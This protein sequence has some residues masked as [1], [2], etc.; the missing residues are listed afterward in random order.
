[1][2][3]ASSPLTRLSSGVSLTPLAIK[4]HAEPHFSLTVID[5]VLTTATTDDEVLPATF[6]G[7]FR[8]VN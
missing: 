2:Q 8:V 3:V 1:M 7:L 5:N 6:F 4:H